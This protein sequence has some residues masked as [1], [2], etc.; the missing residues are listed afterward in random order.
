MDKQELKDAK[1][2][3]LWQQQQLAMDNIEN[4][5]TDEDRRAWEI[6]LT[7]INRALQKARN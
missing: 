7:R 4:A 5:M 3:V 2:S 1:L 6:E